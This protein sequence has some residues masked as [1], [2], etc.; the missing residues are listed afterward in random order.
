MH[1]VVIFVTLNHSECRY[2]TI[3]EPFEAGH[4]NYNVIIHNMVNNL[5]KTIMVYLN[6]NC[7]KFIIALDEVKRK[8]NQAAML[9]SVYLYWIDTNAKS[10]TSIA[11]RD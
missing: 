8:I 6:N 7:N 4:V 1:F 11:Y 3:I 5:N 2:V 9:K 10:N